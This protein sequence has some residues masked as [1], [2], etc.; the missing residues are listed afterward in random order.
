M[1]EIVQNHISDVVQIQVICKLLV[2]KA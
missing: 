1:M 2:P